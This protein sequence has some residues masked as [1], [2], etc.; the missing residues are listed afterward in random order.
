MTA[1]NLFALLAA[2]CLAAPA[3]SQTYYVATTGSNGA[4]G[5]QGSPFLTITHALTTVPANTT[6]I[7][8][9]GNY[10]ENIVINK[11]VCVM[12]QNGR[13]STTITGTANGA[14]GTVLFQTSSANACLKGFKVI[15]FDNGSAGVEN[16]A[17]YV[18]GSHSNLL[19][20]DNEIVAN[21]DLGLLTETT[22]VLPNLTV[23]G[24][25]FSGKT[26]TGNSPATGDQFV[27]PNVPRQ[28]IAL[29]RNYSPNGFGISNLI[30]INNQIT[31]Q[32]GEAS[33]GN[34]PATLE[35]SNALI[36]GNTFAGT[37]AD[38]SGRAGLRVRG[39]GFSVLG[40]T[41]QA[42]P[43]QG[44]THIESA[45]VAVV[46]VNPLAAASNSS[47]NSISGV[48]GNNVFP[49]GAT[50]LN[51]PGSFSAVYTS[52]SQATTA[53]GVVGGGSP[54]A[55]GV[56]SIAGSLTITPNV[57]FEGTPLSTT[58][59][60]MITNNAG[61]N[62]T[63]T[64]GTNSTMGMGASGNLQAVIATTAPGAFTVTIA[65][66]SG[67]YRSS[68]VTNA[69]TPG[70]PP[71]ATGLTSTGDVACGTNVALTASAI[72]D[73]FTFTG[74]K[75]YVFSSVFRN[76]GTYAVAAP[77]V[78][79]P[80]TYTLTVKNSAGGPTATYTTTVGGAACPSGN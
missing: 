35:A 54:V 23:S 6:I 19:I 8:Q 37:T 39:T 48:A 2:C 27:V 7:V 36:Q 58:I 62:Y 15:G 78:L 12:S 22:A 55:A 53:A 43:C 44:C 18:S 21:G 32:A 24:N 29:N 13:G 16:A 34:Y 75:G 68:A 14:I 17:V 10:T 73:V 20:A 5:S 40:N 47:V 57:I 72:G 56:P 61:Y 60:A 63:I 45:S 51:P 64:N 11:N 9:D 46:G 42:A 52:V 74:P 66:T 1:G 38:N 4:N 80:G 50:Y 79:E 31:G 30:F 28:L 76:V 69:V 65:A 70:T 77:N 67:L 25:I 49:A 33:S 71:S 26:Y 3:F 41:F 59:T